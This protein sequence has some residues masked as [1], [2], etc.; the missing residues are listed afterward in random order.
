MR[1]GK[2][3]KRPGATLHMAEEGARE[4]DRH[5]G[6][7]TILPPLPGNC[8]WGNDGEGCLLELM[9]RFKSR[10]PAFSKSQQYKALFFFSHLNKLVNTLKFTFPCAVDQW[11]HL[12]LLMSL[13]SEREFYNIDR[14]LLLI[15]MSA[16]VLNPCR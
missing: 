11:R 16:D 14:G 12:C 3:D 5:N 8:W 13:V 7:K 15:K 9:R 1:D 2:G 4:R 10:K 6:V